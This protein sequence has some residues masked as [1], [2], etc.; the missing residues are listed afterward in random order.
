MSET[1]EMAK[2][3]DP[4]EFEE[5]LYKNWEEKSYF[6]P[7][8]DENKKPYTIVLPPPN[9]TGKLHLGHALDDTLQDILM[10]TKECKAI[11]LYGY[12]DKT[13]L[14]LLQKLKLKMNC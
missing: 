1:R 7:E 11:V 2:T 8:V 12:Q 14:V 13:M 4:K 9:I 6:T 3:Y 10:R 5:R